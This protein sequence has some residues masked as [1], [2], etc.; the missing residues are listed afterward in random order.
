MFIKIIPKSEHL[1]YASSISSLE[2]ISK[3]EA[4]FNKYIHC[5]FPFNEFEKERFPL[6]RNLEKM[7]VLGL[8]WRGELKVSLNKPVLKSA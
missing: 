5:T 3:T 6:E 1:L 7:G 4:C 2:D 8:L